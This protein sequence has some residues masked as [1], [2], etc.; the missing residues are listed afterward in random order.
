MT[1][2]SERV[3][4]E[5]HETASRS[6]PAS[7]RPGFREVVAIGAAG[8]GPALDLGAR[9]PNFIGS[10]GSAVPR[11][12]ATALGFCG[13]GSVGGCAALHATRMGIGEI[14]LIDPGRYK[15]ESLLTH[16]IGPAD[17]GKPKA[18]R[19]GC[20]CKAINPAARIFVAPCSIGDLDEMAL[21]H[22]DVVVLATDR[23]APEV[24]LG[25][26]CLRLGRPVIQASV[27]GATLVAEVRAFTNRTADHPCPA[28]GYGRAEWALL[29]EETVFS[30]AGPGAGRSELSAPTMSISPLCAIAAELA[31]IQ[32]LRLVLGL[33]APVGDGLI[34]YCGFR[35]T[36]T[37]TP[38]VRNPSC[39]CEHVQWS[40]R[41]LP[42]AL[43]ECT[44]RELARQAGQDDDRLEACAWTVGGHAFIESAACC[45]V[46]QPIGRFC[47]ADRPAGRC[48]RCRRELRAQPFFS[49]RRVPGSVLGP[50]LHRP[51]GRLGAGRAP[52]VVVHTPSGAVRFHA[53]SEVTP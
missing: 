26:R 38:L 53:E 34:Q 4:A 35:H 15:P 14:C 24:E 20:L 23:L 13:C 42:G 44:P 21:A 27:D 19:L 30:C 51:L 1:R 43:A 18:S 45:G 46:V 22:V 39:P 3:E 32:V 12:G 10:D 48:P 9:I 2:R 25:Q 50:A 52:W 37:Q 5:R 6:R 28:C 41:P 8:A 49:H 33:G 17:V 29:H 31:M 11:L 36:T 40:P 47:R 16:E 7:G